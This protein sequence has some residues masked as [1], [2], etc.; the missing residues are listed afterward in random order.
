M[1]RVG[2]AY[3]KPLLTMSSTTEVVMRYEHSPLHETEQTCW[4]PLFPGAVIASGFPIPERGN[5]TGLKISLN[6]LAGIGGVQHT[7]EFQ[8]GVVMKGFSYMFVPVQKRDDRVQW[9]AVSS[10]DPDTHLTYRSGL[11][12][13]GSRALSQDVGLDD[14]SKCRAIVGWCSVAQS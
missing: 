8:G 5:E 14:I 2:M 9:H 10:A 6:L 3:A 7:V 13:C 4:L 1:A 12:Q 11:A